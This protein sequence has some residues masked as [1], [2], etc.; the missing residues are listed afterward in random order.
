LS[1]CHDQTDL[2]LSSVR[3]RYGLPAYNAHG[4]LIDSIATA[5]LLLAQIKRIYRDK[6]SGFGR[7]YS[8]SQL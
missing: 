2:R 3:G 8:I 4:A 5:E 7:L 6:K 1:D